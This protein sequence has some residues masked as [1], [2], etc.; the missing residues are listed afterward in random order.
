M[1]I[2]RRFE[3]YIQWL[4]GEKRNMISLVKSWAEISSYSHD[5]EGLAKQ[6]REVISHFGKLADETDVIE[7]TS[8]FRANSEGKSEPFKVNPALS[9]RK[10]PNATKRLFLGG[11]IDTVH[12]TPFKVEETQNRIIGPG[13]ADMKGG[14]VIL[15]KALEAFERSPFSKGLGWEVFINSDEEISSPAS[16]TVLK[17]RAKGHK[18][19]LWYEP[20]IDRKFLAGN[21]KGSFNSTLFFHGAGGHAGRDFHTAKNALASSIRFVQ[22]LEE[23][24]HPEVDINYGELTSGHSHN[25]I[26]S[27]ACLKLNAR[28]FDA[29]ALDGLVPLMHSVAKIEKEKYGIDIDIVDK[30]Y[31]PP[32]ELP[33]DLFKTIKGIGEALDIPLDTRETGGVSD[34]NLIGSVHVPCVDTMGAVGGGIH[35]SGEWLEIDSL[36][37]RAKLSLLYFLEEGATA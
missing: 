15:L 36:V 21:R 6:S 25:V 14:L 22:A 16:G 10:R 35:T 30:T 4:D 18:A 24:K 19:A 11:H 32:K 2:D 37:E 33:E 23:R 28:S 26:P 20:A 13:V 29:R 12:K 9:F 5:L 7:L 34:G 27:L 8:A 31:R 3:P 1:G 17:E